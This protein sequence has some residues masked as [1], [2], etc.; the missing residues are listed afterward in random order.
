MLIAGA[1]PGAQGAIALL[2]AETR[3]V[4]ACIDMPMAGA[5]LMV[6][7]LVRDIEQTLD[8]RRIGAIFIEKQIPFAREGR[9]AGATSAFNM[10][11]RF[12]AIR[13]IAA[14]FGWPTEIVP[15]A[16]WQKHFSITKADKSRSLAIAGEQMPLD[17]DLWAHG[18]G[19]RSKAQAIGRA[20]AALIAMYAV[21]ALAGIAIGHSSVTPAQP[22][23]AE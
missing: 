15:P 7:E 11:Q 10:G 23:A 18:R 19:K 1:D 6:R 14:C 2:N 16:K 8:G 20:E 12:M 17:C 9:H 22:I 13:A 3:R 5:E 21:R 4:L